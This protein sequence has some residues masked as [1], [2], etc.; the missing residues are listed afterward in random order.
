MDSQYVKAD[1]QIEAETED[2]EIAKQPEAITGKDQVQFPINVQMDSQ[3]VEAANREDTS[4]MATPEGNDT[5][6]GQEENA[7]EKKRTRTLV[8]NIRTRDDRK[9]HVLPEFDYVLVQR[10]P[11]KKAKCIYVVSDSESPSIVISQPEHN[12]EPIIEKEKEKQILE[13]QETEKEEA[14]GRNSKEEANG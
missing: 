14:S 6:D 10:N 4:N 3:Y 2:V 9:T 7:E 1:V 5:K 12:L 13:E 8:R 11:K